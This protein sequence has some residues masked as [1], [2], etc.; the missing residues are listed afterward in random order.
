M[1]EAHSTGARPHIAPSARLILRTLAWGTGY[2]ILGCL[3]LLTTAADQ[4]LVLVAP[5]TGLGIIWFSTTT[6]RSLPYDVSALVVAIV[7]L[8]L[9][10]DLPTWLALLNPIPVLLQY[11]LFVALMRHWT[12]DL[13]PF[14]GVRTFWRLRDLGA[15]LA[16]AGLAALL[17]ALMITGLQHLAGL[18]TADLIAILVRW[19]RGT[20][21]IASIGALGLLAHG[22]LHGMGRSGGRPALAAR[23]AAIPRQRIIEGAALAIS[24]GL[25]YVLVFEVLE[26]YPLTFLL[27]AMTGWAGARFTPIAVAAHGVAVGTV[28]VLSTLAG[29]GSFAL[30]EDHNLQAWFVQL[31]V[32]VSAGAGLSLAL[33]RAELKQAQEVASHRASLLDQVLYGID[34]GV[35]V[36]ERPRTI[37]FTNPAARRV[38][39]LDTRSDAFYSDPP[40]ALLELDGQPIPDSA[41]PFARVLRG[42]TVDDVEMLLRWHDG[43]K[44]LTVRASGYPIT[45]SDPGRERRALIRFQDVTTERERHEALATFAG[46]VAHDLRN[47]LTIV[48]AWTEEL[49]NAF[50]SADSVHRET[51]LPIV[52]RVRTAALRMGAFIQ[53]LLNFTL[54]RDRELRPE[55]VDLVEVARDVASARGSTPPDMEAPRISVSGS[56]TAQ[57][58]PVLIRIVLD[59]LVANSVKYVDPGVTP[60]ISIEVTEDSEDRLQVSVIDNGIGIAPEHRE[61]VFESFNRVEDRIADG[62]GLGLGICQRIITR[63]GG[64]IGIAESTSGTRVDFSLPRAP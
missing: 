9:Q 30:V 14:G 41:T 23:L 21:A 49:T 26:G 61:T 2:Y 8:S 58:D 38:L 7:A 51:G 56:G 10:L 33:T 35:I 22:A 13:L 31:F 24:S 48:Q 15:F 11:G 62:T 18:T 44:T 6:R 17:A 63:H 39:D 53:D 12:P 46:H 45:R 42:E 5:S 64:T 43:S 55:P 34:E 28:A 40:Y 3:A 50:E 29:H 1:R 36:L 59:N 52:T 20:A 19:G 27:F 54:A 16:A 25:A 57:A 32:L 4:P 60:E 37:V 47:P